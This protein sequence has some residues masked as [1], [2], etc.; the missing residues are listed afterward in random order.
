HDFC[1]A[2]KSYSNA[3]LFANLIGDT[4]LESKL[5]EEWNNDTT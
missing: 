5:V 3:I 4:Y 2:K 1:A